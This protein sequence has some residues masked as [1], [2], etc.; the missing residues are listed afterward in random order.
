VG[1]PNQTEP[2]DTRYR[3]QQPLLLLAAAA[4][5]LALFALIGLAASAE[6]VEDY[7][8]RQLA[9]PGSEGDQSNDPNDPFDERDAEPR[10]QDSST[11][12]QPDP[13]NQT[14]QLVPDENGRYFYPD[15]GVPLEAVR[16]TADGQLEPV[17]IGDLQSGD[18]PISDTPEG[19]VAIFDPA[20][21]SQVEVLSTGDG[22]N[23]RT[24]APG[25]GF[26]PLEA[27]GD[28]SVVAIPAEAFTDEQLASADGDGLL[29]NPAEGPIELSFTD[30]G[31]VAGPLPEDAVIINDVLDRVFAG[32]RSLPWRW[33][34]LSYSALAVVSLIGAYV[35]H[36]RRPRY[37][38]D[39]G[40][41]S[42]EPEQLHRFEQLLATLAA[43]PD[44]THAV[45]VA[46]SVAERGLGQLAPRRAQETPYEWYHRLLAAEGRN[47]SPSTLGVPQ[48]LAQRLGPVCDLYAR[49]RFAPG[50]STAADQQAMVSALRDLYAVA[51]GQTD[52]STMFGP[53]LV[54]SGTRPHPA[55]R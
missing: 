45:C 29:L 6:S 42:A 41:F 28:G 39:L 3:Y 17:E 16:I 54:G 51:T 36:R 34:F 47:A 32:S 48:G 10:P 21:G 33:V 4:G 1:A 37:Q 43:E 7:R 5:A 18:F 20:G 8:E 40:P 27:T 25:G 13:S 52:E 46:F 53:A 31:L 44:P 26:R 2:A 23:G 19:G 12:A 24:T 9:G 50:Q 55:D 30:E 38:L 11:D 14:G 15:D 49:A 22:V 35:M